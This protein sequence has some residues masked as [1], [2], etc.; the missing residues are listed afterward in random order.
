MT[1]PDPQPATIWRY[2]LN[3]KEVLEFR[4]D[5]NEWVYVTI[6]MAPPAGGCLRYTNEADAFRI[7]DGPYTEQTVQDAITDYLNERDI[8]TIVGTYP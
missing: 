4:W 6:L 2:R 8:G 1:L 5:R 7:L 3:T